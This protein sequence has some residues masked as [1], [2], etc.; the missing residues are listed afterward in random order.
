MKRDFTFTRTGS[1]PRTIYYRPTKEGHTY[2][3]YKPQVLELK[4]KSIKK[5]QPF[6][7][8][9]FSPF[10][11]M[12]LHILPD[13]R[14]TLIPEL[15]PDDP[16]VKRRQNIVNDNY[17]ET[18]TQF[19]K[20]NQMNLNSNNYKNK[21]NDNYNNFKKPTKR[22][23]KDIPKN[24]NN[25]NFLK[26]NLSM[27]VNNSNNFNNNCNNNDISYKY[28]NTY[29]NSNYFN[30]NDNNNKPVNL[31]HYKSFDLKTKYDY[32]SEIKNLPGSKMRFP[33]E[34]KDDISNPRN[35]NINTAYTLKYNQ[36]YNSQINCLK[37]NNNNN[38]NNYNYNRN[39]KRNKTQNNILNKQNNY[40]NKISNQNLLNNNIYNYKYKNLSQF[41]F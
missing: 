33:N 40:F 19:G 15:S 37:D 24:N 8:E 16:F 6:S 10:R 3:Y 28:N 5:I 11:K 35:K 31:K 20:Y 14:R 34:I 7:S 18:I 1:L 32:S 27:N 30:T 26:N 21:N 38:N 29:S 12:N 36:L 17:R 41:N 25:N 22:I 13:S 4:G 2:S 9:E 39:Y 23:I